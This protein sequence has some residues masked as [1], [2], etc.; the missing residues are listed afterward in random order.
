MGW[1]NPAYALLAILGV[2][3]LAAGIEDA[4]HRT[5][6][7]RKNLVIALLAPAWWWAA[8]M[9]AWPLLA[10]QLAVAAIVFGLF[11]GVFAAGWM[12]GGDAKL[13]S[14]TALWMGFAS[15]LD[16]LLLASILGAVLTVVLVAARRVPLPG[17]VLRWGWVTRLHHP[18][19]GIPYGVALAAAGLLALPH[20]PVWTIAYGG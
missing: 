9:V 18:R 1:V 7:N 15:L 10:I 11:V 5:I 2:L 8:G 3:L 20:S 4:R 6:S 16:Y 17:S 13:A 19:T 14:A 12:G